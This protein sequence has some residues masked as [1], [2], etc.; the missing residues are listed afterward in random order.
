[1]ALLIENLYAFLASWGG[2]RSHKGSVSTV[3]RLLSIKIDKKV[4]V[5]TSTMLRDTKPF[6]LKVETFMDKF[7]ADFPCFCNKICRSKFVS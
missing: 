6:Y 2:G 3:C 1:M 7:N 4:I 5:K